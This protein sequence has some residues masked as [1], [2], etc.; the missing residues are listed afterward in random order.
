MRR[1]VVVLV[2]FF[3]FAATGAYAHLTGAFAD[4]LVSVHDEE[5]IAKLKLEMQR[6]KDDIEAMTPQV[7][8]KEQVFSA[9]RNSAAAQLQF[10]DD[11]G[12]DAWLSLMLQAQDP[13]DI[14][15]G[16]WLMA[17]SLDRYM[18]E[19]D[20]LYAEYMQVKTA[21]ESLEGHQRLLM[22][23]ERQL[24]ARARFITDNSDAAIDQLAN[25]LD[26]DWMS[27]VEE[28]LLQ[29]LASDRELADKQ[30]PQWA[31]PGTAAG[32]LYKLEEQWLNDRSELAYFF[33]ADHIYAVYEK[34]DL[35]VMLI[36]QL[37]NKENGTADLQFEAG[38]FNGFLMPD[39]LLEELRGFAVGTAGLEA[40]AGSPAPYYWQ[41]ANGALL[42]RTNE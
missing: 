18:Q 6:T 26:I 8:Q 9:R 17:R 40:A 12:M 27:E 25:Y 15:G 29:S 23:M 36:G 2:L 41:Q 28:P 42:L 24:Q 32:A 39:T 16:Q 10:Y 38:F 14:I 35:H 4:F 34:P 37:L 7:R 19:L 5:T 1:T 3:L 33:R 11:F 22:G 13:V 30:L 31:V 20:R 21:R